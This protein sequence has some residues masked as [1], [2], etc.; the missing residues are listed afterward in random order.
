MAILISKQDTDITTNQFYRVEASQL[1]TRAN[2]VEALST[3]R[4]IP[5][6]FANAGNCMG[7]V[8]PLQTNANQIV[9]QDFRSVT[10]D[11][12][13]LVAAVWTTRTSVTLTRAQIFT[14]PN[15]T[16][17]YLVPFEFGTPYAV[18]TTAGIW[19]FNIAS[20]AG[21]QTVHFSILK[22]TTFYSY[23]AW[24][25]TQLTP[26]S[27][28]DFIIFKNYVDITTSYTFKAQ[29]GSSDI[30]Y[31]YCAWVCRNLDP[32][33]DNVAYFRIPNTIASPVTITIDGFVICSTH[34][35]VRAGTAAAPHAAD[36]CKFTYVTPTAG[37]SYSGFIDT[38]AFLSSG[39][40]TN[41]YSLFFYG[42]SPAS[43]GSVS[44]NTCAI[45]ASTIDVSDPTAFAVDD[46]I[47]IGKRTTNASDEAGTPKHRIT[48]IAGNT[49]TFTPVLATVG[50]AIG[51]KVLKT[52]NNATN[53][54][55]YGVTHRKVGSATPATF[56]S[57]FGVLSNWIMSGV[58]CEHVTH[59]GSN[60]TGSVE[61]TQ[62][63]LGYQFTNCIFLNSTALNA[64][65]AS[66]QYF[67]NS[68]QMP[69]STCTFR[70]CIFTRQG[71]YTVF[72]NTFVNSGS[73]AITYYGGTLNMYDCTFM[74]IPTNLVVNGGITGPNGAIIL[75]DNDGIYVDSLGG[76][77]VGL[78][79]TGLNSRWDN[80]EIWGCSSN[81]IDS[82]GIRVVNFING[83]A[84]NVTINNSLLSFNFEQINTGSTISNLTVGNEVANTV[85]FA[86]NAKSY[87]DIAV[88]TVTGNPTFDASLIAQSVGGS[89]IKFENTNA[90]NVDFV[91][92]TYGDIYR[93]GT[94]LSD[95]TV[96]T[97]GGYGLRFQPKSSVYTTYWSQNIP[98]G[99]IQN[100]TMT[101]GIFIRIN[102]EAYWAGTH[103]MPRLTVTYDNGASS[104]YKEALQVASDTVGVENDGWQYVSV[105]ITPTTTFGQITFRID[106]K[107]DAT[108]SNAYFYIDD[109]S[110]PL[111]QG[112]TLNLGKLDLFSDGLP[113]GPANFASTISAAEVWSA[114]P[115]LFGAGTI[116]Y[117]IYKIL[118]SIKKLVS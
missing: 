12:Q 82:G 71:A 51:A 93:T 59:N 33:P 36:Y 69:F 6:T 102:K 45:G 104:E 74:R 68:G 48:G 58:F 23:A 75:Q 10:V 44:T 11:L 27:G 34:G 80:V 89:Q 109:F 99:N 54:T 32:T 78:F 111:P 91:K 57:G 61:P 2:T 101:I 49:L 15:P 40:V 35:G 31:G 55:G 28:T 20:A 21:A 112:A 86:C 73:P 1:G 22:S 72:V 8:I 25:D 94:G 110:A 95:T 5:V 118:K 60:N 53:A 87:T 90:T 56:V 117:Y 113:V 115:T 98:T 39:A 97:A 84:N 14:G 79:F 88:K 108:T 41:R 24:C 38:S 43:K 70:D 100:L 116:G 4:Q 17:S 63:N 42:V 66:Y 64:Y 96:R 18:N 92:Q 85:D 103:Q 52:Y 19:R 114:D 107:T 7:I 65:A 47:M 77:R 37:T 50:S 105:N 76:G 30:I 62:Y 29:L 16:G 67:I 46:F 83:T 81:G 9:T 106:G 3:A 13:E 26:V